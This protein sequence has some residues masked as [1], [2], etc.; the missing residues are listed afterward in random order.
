MKIPYHQ[1]VDCTLRSARSHH[2][3]CQLMRRQ[4]FQLR[5]HLASGSAGS[6]LAWPGLLVG[7]IQWVIPGGVSCGVRSFFEGG[8]NTGWIQVFVAKLV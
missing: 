3:E 2:D 4:E 1:P 5:S 7:G 8:M 6:G